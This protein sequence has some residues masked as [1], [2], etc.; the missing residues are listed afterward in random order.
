MK[1]NSLELIDLFK[2][3]AEKRWIRGV[4]KSWGDIGL[5]FEHEIGKLPDST[6][7]PDYKDIE[8]KCSS[9]YSQFPLFMFTLAFDGPTDF[10]ISRLVEKYGYYDH[11]FPDK[12][13]I[14]RKIS[15]EH[16]ENNKYNFSFEVDRGKEKIYLCVYNGKGD[17]LERESYITFNSLKEHLYT[18]MKKIAYIKASAK[19]V[20]GINYYRYYLICMY[21]LKEFDVF[22]NLLEKDELQITLISRISKSG[23]F[24][25]K[26]KNKNIEF[27]IKKENIEKLFTCFEK[28]NNDLPLLK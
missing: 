27:A 21:K 14:F 11:D 8:I 9:R 25:G 6:Y 23:V 13:V 28:Y 2:K 7:N 17:L 20:N 12:K 22:L 4:G 1:D 24:K 19:K 5:T 18:K 16:N 10:E 3:V 26:Y 15:N